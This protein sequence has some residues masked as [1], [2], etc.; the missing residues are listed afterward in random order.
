[1]KKG[2]ALLLA[3]A[4]GLGGGVEV[5]MAGFGDAVV[6]GVVGGVV[7][8][9]ITN[10]IIHSRS[11]HRTHRKRRR[12]RAAPKPVVESDEMKIQRALKSLGY[13]RGPIDGQINSFET[14]TAIKEFNR[15]YE[16]SDTAYMSPQ[17]RDALIYLG[18]LLKMDRALISQG[19]DRRSKTKRIQA[20]LKV[21]G[22]YSG[23]VDGATGPMTRRAISSY[24]EANGMMP[25]SNLG[26][27][28]EYRLITTA[29]QANDRN[30]QETLASLKR[31]G[32]QNSA[33]MRQPAV[34]QPMQPVVLQP[35]VQQA[36]PVQPTI[37]QSAPAPARPALAPAP[38]PQPP[39]PVHAAP[40]ALPA[41]AAAPA[42]PQAPALTPVKQPVEAA[43]KALDKAPQPIQPQ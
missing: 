5:A 13:Y 8:S 35:A 25:G 6:G 41:P 12:H 29:K 30:I 10:G 1:M 2:T 36:A 3:G 31:L 28:E 33:R 14:R 21:L 7:G 27:E 18:T 23:K 38:L 32:A 16:I 22:H 17:E 37:T 4:L 24:R 15:A 40:A 39:Q 26:Y 20:A 34:Q 43:Q 42:Q 9:V 11:R 19:S